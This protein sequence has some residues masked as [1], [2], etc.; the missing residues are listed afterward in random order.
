MQHPSFAY[1]PTA[2]SQSRPQQFTS[3]PSDMH[4]Y[5]PV[6]QQY[7]PQQ[8]H[9]LP[10]QQPIYS[11]QPVMNMHQMAT[12]NAFRGAMSMTPIASPQPSH[13]KPT[14]VVQQGSPGLMP[15]DTRFVNHEYY[16]FPSTPPLS[17]TGS[18]VSSP[19]SSINGALN[20]PLNDCFSFEKV[21]GVKEG[22]EGDVH[23][24]ILANADWTRCDSP[25][26]TPGKSY[27]LSIFFFFF[28]FV[29]ASCLVM[30][31]RKSNSAC[32]WIGANVFPLQSSSTPLPSPPAR[33][34]SSCP[35]TAPAH[36]FPPLPPRSQPSSP[37]RSRCRLSSPA[38]TSAIPAS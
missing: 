37:S 19:P 23:A 24:E 12:T 31:C 16:N 1:Y 36:P 5:G 26:M 11:A 21:E 6:Q 9:C 14:I 33:V 17:A 22:C 8:S 27:H 18:S 20:T 10:D 29:L 15:L 35:P 32:R 34:R 3:H 30:E 4:Y 38:P 7:Q 13:L 25:P 2:D 28:F